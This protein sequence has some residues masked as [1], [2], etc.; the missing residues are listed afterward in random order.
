MKRENKTNNEQI[1]KEY[2][3]KKKNL[4]ESL[5]DFINDPDYDDVNYN[6]L[7][8]TIKE[9]KITKNHNEFEHFLRLLLNISNNH[10]R[11]SLFFSKIERIIKK[12]SNKIKRTF[13][14]IKIFHIFESNKILLLFI[15][16][17]N[18]IQLN[19]LIINEMLNYE[20]DKRPR[21]FHFFIQ[22]MKA[23]ASEDMKKKI[24][25]EIKNEGIKHDDEY[26]DQKRI[27]G[28]N[29]DY[30]CSLIRNDSI[31]EF[32]SFINRN[33]ISI[34]SRILTSI[35]ETNEFLIDKNPTLIEYAAFFGSIQIFNYLLLSNATISEQMWEYGIHSN[36]AEI[37]HLLEMNGIEPSDGTYERCLEESIKCHHNLISIYIKDNLLK[38]SNIKINHQFNDDFSEYEIDINER[39]I[40]YGIKYENYPYFPEDIKQ[41]YI[42]FYI[43]K[44]RYFKLVKTFISNKKDEIKAIKIQTNKIFL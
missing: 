12:Y 23:N 30:I 42:F 8:K 28:E 37:I 7:I 27:E 26:Y 1:Y 19:D 36:K 38:N 22:E 3:E 31:D 15:I 33:R 18:I 14:N 5:L 20:K 11:D 41:D 16:K 43:S 32:V 10:H 29:D 40:S 34:S 6:D 4:H 25:Q 13:S 39:I 9:Q 21:F 2:I 35:Y 44:Y 17:E 24:E